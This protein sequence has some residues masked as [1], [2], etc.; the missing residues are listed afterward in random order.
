MLIHMLKKTNYINIYL[1]FSSA[2]H[3][4]GIFY[5]E[6]SVPFQE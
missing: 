4:S 2:L 3:A 1:W 6:I 5:N